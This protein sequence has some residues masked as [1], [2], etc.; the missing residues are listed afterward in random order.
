MPGHLNG[1]IQQVIMQCIMFTMHSL[2]KCSSSSD[3]PILQSLSG[4]S[5][6]CFS[7]SLPDARIRLEKEQDEYERKVAQS[8]WLKVQ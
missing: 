5:A 2:S 1:Q 6:S 8:G 4:S 3:I 7:A